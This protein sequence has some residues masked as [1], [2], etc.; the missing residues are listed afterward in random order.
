MSATLRALF[1]D[2]A[3]FIV[4]AELIL[5]ATVGVI[6]LVV[7]LAEVSFNV[8]EELEDVGTAVGKISQSYDVSSTTGHKARFFGSSF[9]DQG[10]FCDDEH[11]INCDGNMGKWN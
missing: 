3:G 11:D 2:E 5:V 10:D 7:G 8:C 4:S 9:R 1:N 6:A